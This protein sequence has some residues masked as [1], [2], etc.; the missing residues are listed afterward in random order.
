VLLE[1]ALSQT[2]EE[3][4]RQDWRELLAAQIDRLDIPTVQADVRPFLEYPE[5]SEWITRD[6][7]QGL[8]GR[9]RQG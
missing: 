6:H 5:E 9:A 4:A 1:E 8:L 7:L 3:L 2:R